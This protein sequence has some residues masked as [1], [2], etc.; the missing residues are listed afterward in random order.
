MSSTSS[1]LTY[2]RALGVGGELGQFT[3]EQVFPLGGFGVT[4]RAWDNK[5]NRRVA[6]KEYLPDH[7]AHRLTG[8]LEVQIKDG[9]EAEYRFG[10]ERYLDEAR[11]LASFNHPNI[12]KVFDFFEANNSA[13]IVMEFA[14]GQ[15]LKELLVRRGVLDQA[16]CLA[17]FLP[18]LK[19]LETVH[20]GGF[21][22]RDIKP[23]N[24]YI[25]ASADSDI[26]EPVLIDF[27][28]ARESLGNQ[29]RTVTSMVS[30]GYAPPEQYASEGKWLGP[31][32]DLYAL[33]ASLYHCVAGN[34]PEEATSRQTHFY[35][36][37]RDSLRPAVQM[38]G[39]AYSQEFLEAVDWLMALKIKRRPQTVSEVLSRFSALPGGVPNLL[40]ASDSSLAGTSTLDKLSDGSFDNLS[41]QTQSDSSGVVSDTDQTQLNPDAPLHAD[42]HTQLNSEPGRR[43][44]KQTSSLGEQ[45]FKKPRRHKTTSVSQPEQKPSLLLWL[46]GAMMIVIVALVILWPSEPDVIHT[47][48]IGEP[49]GSADLTG[50]SDR[51]ES[52]AT[53]EQAFSEPT[54]RVETEQKDLPVEPACNSRDPKADTV[55]SWQTGKVYN[56]G[57]QVSFDGLVWRAKWWTQNERPGDGE[58]WQLVSQVQLPWRSNIAYNAGHEVNHQGIRYRAR[59]WTRGDSPGV[60]EVWLKVGEASC[61]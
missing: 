58:V 38:G 50:A 12:I 4:Y 44:L 21:L 61:P 1:T 27:G 46:S 33:G 57:E 5:L 26:G 10:L 37:G 3:I 56:G 9:C 34:A 6:I 39:A 23:A 55:A 17:I 11:V 8:Q 16:S 35:E 7:L 31:W 49:Q 30:L 40:A 53:L 18:I 14:Q 59:W 2:T 42:A 51:A 43:E 15:S 22:H 45:S 25:R 54:E 29:T 60:G 41:D 13:Y 28:A 36:D 47:E 24:I 48:I 32:S 20:A 52:S 19:G